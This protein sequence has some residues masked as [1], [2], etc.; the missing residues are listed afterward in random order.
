M[1]NTSTS[2][3]LRIL[4]LEPRD[5]GV[6]TF[7]ARIPDG[8]EEHIN[9]TLVIHA[10]PL[11]EIPF[12]TPMYFEHNEEHVL[13]CWVT[14]VPV[15]LI[16]WEFQKCLT[17]ACNLTPNKWIDVTSQKHLS[18]NMENASD[19]QLGNDEASSALSV[20][21]VVSGVY[22]CIGRNK[23]GKNSTQVPFY[24]SDVATGFG[25]LREPAGYDLLTDMV[26]TVENTSASCTCRANRLK[27]NAPRWTLEDGGEVLIKNNTMHGLTVAEYRTKY[28]HVAVLN[29]DGIELQMSG[30]YYC[31]AVEQESVT[32]LP[33]RVMPMAME[34]KQIQPP[35]WISRLRGMLSRD[36]ESMHNMTCQ[37]DGFP[38]PTFMWYKDGVLLDASTAT[39]IISKNITQGQMLIIERLVK[40]D[41]GLYECEASNLGDIIRSGETLK[42]IVLAEGGVSPGLLVGVILAILI[43]CILAVWLIWKL[44]FRRQLKKWAV[45]ATRELNPD[46]SIEGEINPDIPIQDQAELLS[47][48]PRYEFPKERLT[49]GKKLGQGAF[50]CVMRAQAVGIDEQEASTT[51]AVKMLK[52]RI[53]V[54]MSQRKAL[55]SEIKILIHIGHHLNIVNLLGVITKHGILFLI[56]EYCKFGSLREFL[57]KNRSNFV[58]EPDGSNLDDDSV[59]NDNLT[60]TTGL[61]G[62]TEGGGEEGRANRGQSIRKQKPITVQDLLT[63]AYQVAR[64]MEFL[65]SQKCIHR[66]LAA[67]NVLVADDDVVKICDF[68]LAKDM[69]MYPDYVKQS[70]G[71]MPIKWM[72]LESI[73]DKVFSS[74]SDVWAFGILLYEMF[75]LG[76]SPYPGIEINNEFIQ[77]LKNGYRMSKPIYAPRETYRVMQE[78]WKEEPEQR[79][80]FHQLVQKIGNMLEG[81]IRQHYLDLNNTYLRL[82]DDSLDQRAT[83]NTSV[84]DLT[85]GGAH[86]YYVNVPDEHG[87]V[88][89]PTPVRRDEVTRLTSSNNSN[90]ADAAVVAAT[91]PPLHPGYDSLPLQTR[92]VDVDKSPRPMRKVSERPRDELRGKPGV[93]YVTNIP[94]DGVGG[95]ARERQAPRDD[96]EKFAGP[97]SPSYANDTLAA[98]RGHLTSDSDT[99]SGYWGENAEPPSYNVVMM[100]ATPPSSPRDDARV[101]A[102]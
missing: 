69:E 49:L 25:I 35:V 86:P 29:F 8:T 34:V 48:D 78:C 26:E 22:R 32:E 99:S 37:A 70:A 43:I 93:L 42:V 76:G 67:R 52:E 63:Y 30:T 4:Q 60:Q 9:I 45:I 2:A 94:D 39:G 36:A 101:D 11:V 95:G 24:V 64:G 81:D 46:R 5:A 41:D 73:L 96:G 55:L 21:A 59:T 75:A 91:P 23:L 77:R 97:A 47:F 33:S 19:P 14:G 54:D 31:S 79:P 68:G 20:F 62:D 3:Y 84:T 58:Y 44:Y 72:P 13:H 66:D 18:T 56:M 50:G 87:Y 10:A 15:P 102:V 57:R 90:N 71:P 1:G 28:S 7:S 12:D 51:V 6:Y 89:L 88:N 100:A 17:D 16:T 61:T 82:L 27:Y 65:A 38:E 53:L 85:P 92:K 80:T 83:A 74:Q 40:E 98:P